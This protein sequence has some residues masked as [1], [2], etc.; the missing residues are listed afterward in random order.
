M[1]FFGG[2]VKDNRL[3]G[4]WLAVLGWILFSDSVTAGDPFPRKPI[5]IVVPFGVG[6]GSDT[7]VRVL[8][9]AIRDADLSEQPLTVMN[10]PGAGGTIGSR[11][12]RNARAD[13][14]TLLNLHEGMLTAKYSG[15]ASYGPEAFE[16]VIG[17]GRVGMV[18]T[19]K[20]DSSILDLDDLL[21]AIESTPETLRFAANLG[22]P[23]HFSG[24]LLEEKSKG[25][26]FR[27]VQVGG[28]AKRF[29]ALVGGHADLSVFSVSEFMQFKDSGLRGLA[30]LS[31]VRSDA[32]PEV[33]TASEQG[34]DLLFD[35]TQF[36]W[37]PKGTDP[38][39]KDWIS[40]LLG[41]AMDLPKVREK[42]KSMYVEPIVLRN[43]ELATVLAAKEEAMASLPMRR[44]VNVPAFAPGLL[45]LFAVLFV[46]YV[47][48]GR[49]K[50]FTDSSLTIDAHSISMPSCDV[51]IRVG[52][53]SSY[54][55]L[56]GWRVL[57]FAWLTM[58][59]VSAL[60]VSLAD[61]PKS[62]GP[63]IIA[64]GGVMGFGL[65]WLFGEWLQIDLP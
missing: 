54:L 51:L 16:V 21:L 49:K 15:A 42:L 19:V 45:G 32:I 7:F 12:V 31:S 26:R 11:R 1:A 46:L 34:V 50:K 47:L 57:P 4:L 36:W 55:I 13:G 63:W 65:A 38:A 27:F 17:T 64:V 44:P 22:A 5:K 41:K 33:P 28:G 52:I 58:M 37:L 61:R 25:G 29:S 48:Y 59:F 18:M 40:A 53:I 60:G 6:G 9:Q 2:G 14:Y 62:Q 23:S 8:I 56:L 24:L 35:N 3:A 20:E 10:V 43:S 30:L 39:R